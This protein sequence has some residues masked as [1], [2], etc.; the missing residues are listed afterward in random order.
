MILTDSILGRIPINQVKD[1]INLNQEQVIFRR[2]PGQTAADIAHNC[3]K[4]LNDEKPD[5]VIIM[6]GT[7][8]IPNTCN[9]YEIVEDI[10]KIAHEAKKV[11]AEKICVCSVLVRH[12]HQFKNLVSRINILL[13]AR[14]NE[15]G[16]TFV[17]NSDITEQHI[18]GDGIHPNRYG[19]VILKMNIL[20]CF[21]SFNPYFNTF[22]EFY[23]KAL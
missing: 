9:E 13:E 19:Q 3:T 20:L 22:R 16:Y 10:I 21:Y 2:Y 8:G 18:C 1:N 17:N 11:N 23:E 15:N 6:A 4:P 7:N 5:Q 12:G 14:C